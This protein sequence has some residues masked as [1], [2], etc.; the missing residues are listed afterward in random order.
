MFY[1]LPAAWY[2]KDIIEKSEL[3][4]HELTSN[5]INELENAA[6][7]FSKSDLPLGYIS[8]DNFPLQNF[9]EVVKTVQKELRD[10]IGFTLFRGLPTSR[11]DQRLSRRYFVE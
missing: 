7:T 3:W 6:K 10:G 2:G 8:K 11:Y 1:D 4:L 9:G 5:E